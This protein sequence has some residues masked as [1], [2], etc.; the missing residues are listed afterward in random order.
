MEIFPYS[1]G[2][3]V[4]KENNL[5]GIMNAITKSLIV[6]IKYT[7]VGYFLNGYAWG[8]TNGKIGYFNTKGE[9]IIEF[10]YSFEIANKLLG[11]YILNQNRIL[12]IK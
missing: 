5:Y 4:V 12:K 7:D 11:L 1:N 8:E 6:E 3:A 10:N 2:F 9:T